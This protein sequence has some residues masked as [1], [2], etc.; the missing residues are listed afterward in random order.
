MAID[1][2]HACAEGSSGVNA[3]ALA[4]SLIFSAYILFDSGLT[5]WVIARKAR[6][7]A[8]LAGAGAGTGT[9]TGAGTVTA[10]IAAF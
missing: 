9:G 5:A 1:V 3:L 6:E 10:A 2:S 8:E 4:L 7:R